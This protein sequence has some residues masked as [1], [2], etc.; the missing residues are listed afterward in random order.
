[1]PASKSLGRAVSGF[2]SQ[3]ALASAVRIALRRTH[4]VLLGAGV[5][6]AALL[7]AADARASESLAR[8]ASAPTGIIMN[9]R[10]FNESAGNSV[11]ALGEINGDGIDDFAVGAPFAAYEDFSGLTYVIFGRAGASPLELDL[12]D[13]LPEHGGDG[14]LGFAM[15]GRGETGHSVSGAV[16]VNADGIDDIIVGAPGGNGKAYVVFGTSAGFPALFDLRSLEPDNGGDG[17]RGFVMHGLD[18]LYG[19]GYSVSGTGDVNGDGID[20]L[21][22]QACVDERR[23]ALKCKIEGSAYV[24]FGR[25]TPFPAAFELGSLLPGGGGDGERGFFLLGSELDSATARYVV[26]RAGDLNADGIDDIAIGVNGQNFRPSLAGIIYIVYGRTTPFPPLVRLASLLPGGG[27]DGSQGLVLIGVDRSDHAMAVTAAGDVNGDGID[28]LIIGGYQADPNDRNEAGESYVVFGGAQLPA[29]FPLGTLFP[30]AGGDGMKGFVLKGAGEEHWAGFS[31]NGAGDVNDDGIDDVV[32]GALGGGG[33]KQGA[34]YVFF[35]RTTGF[36]ATFD[37]GALLPPQGGDGSE[38]FVLTG[39]T[40]GDL[41]GNAV[42]SA[43]DVNADGIAD[44]LIGA[45]SAEAGGSYAGRAYLMFGQAT[46]FPANF[47]LGDVVP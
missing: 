1:M 4:A 10:E 46:A 42:S 33:H 3:R 39:E 37:L 14:S 31:V 36:P 23:G 45:K 35:G 12:G 30:G 29:V 13:L 41:A 18:E 17:S 43:G 9:G 24:V 47:N 21:I 25:S 15:G 38:G 19:M 34:A 27:G 32:V 11:A 7:P 44:L 8:D 16:D 40:G 26:S 5:L 2:A 20:D 28:D 22:V 6:A